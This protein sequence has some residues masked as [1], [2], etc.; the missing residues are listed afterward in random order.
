MFKK[1]FITLTVAAVAAIGALAFWQGDF[2]SIKSSH[3]VSSQ[4][5]VLQSGRGLPDFTAL[6]EQA[7]PAVVNISVVQKLRTAGP[8]AGLNPDDPFYEFFRR[9]QGGAPQ[10]REEQQQG[11]G[12]GFIVSADGLVLT[13]AHVVADASEVTVKLTDKREFKARVLGVDR[14]TDVALIKID[15]RDL[16]TVRVGNSSQVKVYDKL[17]EE[18]TVLNVEATQDAAAKIKLVDINSAKK[19]ELKTLPGIGDAEADK[20]IAGRPY[21]SKAWLVGHKILPEDKYPAI[22]GLIIAKQKSNDAAT[23]AALVTKKK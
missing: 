4:P 20:I 8:A 21:G 7:G 17:D 12:S 10:P 16:P 22:K 15:A 9:F 2:S 1:T 3:A 5:A 11:V 23:N 14:R 6:V 19:D 13:N 18:T